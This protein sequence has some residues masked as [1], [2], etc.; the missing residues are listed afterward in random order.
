MLLLKV[1]ALFLS[2]MALGAPAQITGAG[3]TFPYPLYSK[4][5]AE[6]Q[7]VDPEV[8]INYQSIG[9]GGGI[10]QFLKKTVN[11]GATDSPMNE[12]QL[13]KADSEVLHIPTVLGAVVVTYNLP[14]V[15]SGLRLNSEL[16]GE[17][18][19]GKIKKWNDAKLT[20]VNPGVKLS[21]DILVVHR[22]DG[23]GTSG[24]FTDY[25]S[26]T[27]PE[28]KSKVGQGTAVN[29]PVGLGGKGNEGVAGLIKQ[30]SGSIGYVELIYAENNNLPYATLKNSAGHFIKP[31][32]KSVTAAAAEAKIPDDYRVSLT[33]AQGKDAYPI[34]AMTYLLVYKKM[35]D[36]SV[37]SKLV[38]FMNWALGEGQKY[39]EGLKYAPLPASL[40][41]RVV[42]TVK[43][44]EGPDGKKL[45][46]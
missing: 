12:E 33:N 25:L 20:R 1:L 17:I 16:I 11:F 23:S 27:N 2:S 29:W 40:S 43:T 39:A 31:D 46:E 44:I 41:Q 37:G 22:S 35:S 38:K 8:Q 9:S 36:L 3:A 30:T 24:I 5:F 21:G 6:Y 10:Q 28:W 13:K 18:F 32:L 19:L 7:K 42:A 4:W 14:G 45:S 15:A 26:K 34:S